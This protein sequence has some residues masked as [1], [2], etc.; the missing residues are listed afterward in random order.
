M[1]VKDCMFCLIQTYFA[2]SSFATLPELEVVGVTHV[3]VLALVVIRDCLSRR[4]CV[5]YCQRSDFWLHVGTSPWLFLK[6]QRFCSMF[7]IWILWLSNQMSFW[8]P[9]S[10]K[11]LFSAVQVVSFHSTVGN[12][13]SKCPYQTQLETWLFFLAFR[14]QTQNTFAKVHREA[15]SPHALKFVK[16]PLI[17]HCCLPGGTA[18][19]SWSQ[20]NPQAGFPVKDSR[21]GENLELS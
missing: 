16:R 12:F 19:S 20:E 5:W 21:A 14:N 1:V 11:P 17:H 7:P 10:D 2:F 15:A 3:V 6:I 9:F 4:Y 18:Q 8:A 13:S